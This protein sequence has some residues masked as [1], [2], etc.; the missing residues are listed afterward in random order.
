MNGG[1]PGRRSLHGGRPNVGELPLEEDVE[2]EVQAHLELLVDDLVAEG[3]EP[4]AALE[5]A[6][7][8]FGDVNVVRKECETITRSRDRGLRRAHR[9]E[10]MMQDLRYALRNLVRSPG[11]TLV[12]LVTLALGV[13]ANTAI[14]S[15]V[16][17]VL[18]RPL[19]YSDPGRIVWVAERNN[20]GGTMAVAWPNYRDWHEQSTSFV[21]LA[22]VGTGTTTV[23]GGAEPVRAGFTNVT[24]DFWT[25][26]PVRPLAG[27]LTNENDHVQGAQPAVVVARSFAEDVLGG[28]DAVGTVI[29]AGGVRAEVVGVIPDD[30]A[31]PAGNEVWAPLEIFPH[32][33]S[34][35]AH[36]WWVVGRLRDGV[37]LEQADEELD[38]LTLRIVATSPDDDPDYLATGVNMASLQ[39]RVVGDAR[40]PLL[41]LL[42]A[43]AFVLLVACTNL[44]STLLARGTIRSR[45][46]A[47]R[48]SLGAP[49]G[50][51]VRQLL[52]ESVVLAVLGALAGLG[53][54]WLGLD[55]IRRLGVGSLPRLDQVGVD[56]VVLGFTGLI[57]VATALL[58]GLFPALRLTDGDQAEV[59]RTEGRG[60]AGGKGR[61]WSVLVGT[62]VA[63]ALI[64][65]VGSG[66]LIRSFVQLTSQERGF[67]ES[68]VVVTAANL[69]ATRYPDLEDIRGFFDDF[70]ARASALPGVSA[71]GVSSS[72][73]VQGYAASGRLELDGDPEKFADGIYVTT[74][75]GTFE[76]LDIPLVRGRMFDDRD[77]EG[78]PDVAIVN[79]AFADEFWP[80][81]D[82]IGHTVT[83]GGMD[84]FWDADPPR[85]ATVVGVVGDV[86]YRDLTRGPEPTVYF[87]Y[88][89][90]PFRL[91]YQASVVAESAT[92]DP[93][94]VAP[95]LR[96]ALRS[97]DPNLAI[98]VRYLSAQ[99]SD[100]LAQRRFI[101]MVLGIF[102]GV[103]LILAGVGIYGV[104]SYA[105]ARRTREMG[106]R[107]SLGAA[108]ATVQR[109]VMA[110]ALRTVAVGLVVGVAG[111]LVLVRLMQGLLFGVS[112]TDPTTF[113]VVVVLLLGTAILATWIPARRSTRI[114]PMITMRAE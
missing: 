109:L 48:S 37:T 45:E 47:V 57:A 3:W 100:S 65:L 33:E 38:A 66:L 74:S 30:G 49:R 50:R 51:L 11:F 105:V 61:V 93:A 86:R 91:Q 43:A 4:A 113:A 27:R 52:T 55:V 36:N 101:L 77:R 10:G 25:V 108:P 83:G 29:E 97:A 87:A 96:Q 84:N 112:S 19:S 18:L 90:R 35:T 53:V 59:L 44:A 13:G 16:N 40:T 89:Q 46:L 82:P 75:P 12:A 107:L 88:G 103:A 85:F 20:R 8:R 95:L 15:V 7:R 56:G 32:G 62:E 21:G 72:L 111:G 1:R 26:F 23:V 69:S 6:R 110:G 104:V 39:D 9:V 42:G 68:D 28:L 41:I 78:A 70:L 64:L 58:F 2:R 79:Q 92:G 94:A 67:D 80:G 34:R 106:I 81:E 14:F 54:A 73:P 17:G 71:V 76:A 102:A 114:D 5:E 24:R 98:E 63:L 60:S 99:V 22:A 31:Y